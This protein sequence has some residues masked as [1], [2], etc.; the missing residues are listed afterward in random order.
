MGAHRAPRQRKLSLLILM[1]LTGCSSSPTVV[2][3]TLQPGYFVSR[4]GF[5]RYR[6]PSGWF[7]ATADSQATGHTIWLLR[8]DYI[9]SITVDEIHLDT[10]ARESLVQGSLLQLAQLTMPL[11]AADRAASVNQKPELSSINGKKFCT[12]ELLANSQRDILRVILFDVDSKVYAATILFEGGKIT[13]SREDIGSV[14]GSFIK[15]LRW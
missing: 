12:Y 11:V 4:D 13:M 5:L 15:N 8:N 2:P 7:D 6:V 3:V 14:Q 1:L 10:R 9:V